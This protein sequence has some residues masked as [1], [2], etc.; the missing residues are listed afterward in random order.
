M[1]GLPRERVIV[2]LPLNVVLEPHIWFYH[3]LAS[4]PSGFCRS[5][6]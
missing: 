3:L 5:Q 1:A 6:I 4:K 2:T